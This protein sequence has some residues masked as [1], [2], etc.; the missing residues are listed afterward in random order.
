MTSQA[1]LFSKVLYRSYARVAWI[2]PAV[3]EAVPCA[4]KLVLP[5]ED[6]EGALTEVLV[7]VSP[8]RSFS[9]LSKDNDKSVLYVDSQTHLGMAQCDKAQ[10]KEAYETL[11]LETLGFRIDDDG[12]SLFI[13]L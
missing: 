12:K 5:S 6:L 7:P 13:E 11:K 9:V 2:A 3:K 4:K 8:G 10:F 1:D